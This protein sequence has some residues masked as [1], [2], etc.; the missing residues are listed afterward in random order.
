MTVSKD[1]AEHI[2]LEPLEDL[3]VRDVLEPAHPA[4]SSI[5]QEQVDASEALPGGSDDL[6]R[7]RHVELDGE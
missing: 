6:V 4:I 5:V 2:R 7:L 1:C 3:L